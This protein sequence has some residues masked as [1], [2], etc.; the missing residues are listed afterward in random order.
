MTQEERRLNLIEE[1]LKEGKYNEQIPQ[2]EQGQRNLLRS[3]MN[4]RGPFPVS[5]EFL[6][7]QDEYLK[8]RNRE[9][10]LID[11]N[12]L[13]PF[14]ENNSHLYLW[15]GDITTLKVDAIVNAANSALL[16]CFAPLHICIDNCIHTFA[17]I[18][19]RLA[20]NELMEK[21]GKPEATGL[22]KITPAFNLPS[23]ICASY[24]GTYNQDSGWATG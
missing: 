16:G 10:G 22:C 23:N 20:C 13:K 12:A 9:R 1:L 17:G 4:V 6:K 14:S 18:Q 21:Q 15:Q 24:C 3:L 11:V 19:L 8:E 2:D 7:V 5:D